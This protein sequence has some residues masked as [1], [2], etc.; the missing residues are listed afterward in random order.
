MRCNRREMPNH[1]HLILNP[2][3]SQALSR[4]VGEAHGLNATRFPAFNPVRAKPC[5]AP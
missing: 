3:A 4:A 5:A 1:I 2:G